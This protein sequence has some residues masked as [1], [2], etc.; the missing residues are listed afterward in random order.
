MGRETTRSYRQK[1]G[2]VWLSDFPG[3]WTYFCSLLF[4]SQLVSGDKIEEPQT[5][6]KTGGKTSYTEDWQGAICLSLLKRSRGDLLPAYKF[7]PREEISGTKKL[8]NLPEK[9]VTRANG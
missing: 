5:L 9:A 4:S 8:F 1:G 3:V 7:L 6:P 2:R